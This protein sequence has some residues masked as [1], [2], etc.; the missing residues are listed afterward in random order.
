MM[1]DHVFMVDRIDLGIL[2]LLFKNAKES[3][4]NI[5]L[6]VG[7]FSP[8]AISRR[9]KAL[10]DEGIIRKYTIDV[11]L[12]KIGYN[13]IT[14]TFVKAKFSP[15]YYENVVNELKKIKNIIS[16]Y[17]ILG[18]IDFVLVTANKSKEDYESVL[19]ELTKIV[20]IERTDSRTV[21]KIYK[22]NDVESLL[23]GLEEELSY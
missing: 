18:D 14:I 7:I 17:F 4:K 12:N 20:D 22:E 1:D 6:K 19:R 3:L 11:D 21:L 16:I 15:E 23:K 10:E 2:R 8:S 9:I 5:G 13:F